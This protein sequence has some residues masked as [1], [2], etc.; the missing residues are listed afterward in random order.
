MISC[1]SARRRELT[2]FLHIVARMPKAAA[3]PAFQRFMG[4]EV[5]ERNPLSMSMVMPAC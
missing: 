5:S 1:P 4:L 3:E 2:G